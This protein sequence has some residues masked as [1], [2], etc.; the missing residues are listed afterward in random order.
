MIAINLDESYRK[1][2]EL[3]L[4]CSRREF[5]RNLLDKEVGYLSAAIFRDSLGTRGGLRVMKR[6]KERLDEV[7]MRM[8]QSLRGEIAE[9]AGRLDESMRVAQILAQGR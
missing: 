3:G 8:P 4:V 9:V 1:L 6:L 2:R 7:A 5:S